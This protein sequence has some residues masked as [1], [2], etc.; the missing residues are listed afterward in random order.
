MPKGPSGQ[1]RSACPAGCQAEDPLQ[2]VFPVNQLAYAG[3]VGGWLRLIAIRCT[4]CGCVYTGV[5][6]A[7]TIRGWYDGLHAGWTAVHA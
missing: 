1:N 5:G 6:P 3:A 7:R 2:T 4:F